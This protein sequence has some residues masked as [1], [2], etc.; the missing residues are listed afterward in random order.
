[1]DEKEFKKIKKDTMKTFIEH[2]SRLHKYIMILEA[3]WKK[4]KLQKTIPI[5]PEYYN[6]YT[7]SRFDHIKKEKERKTTIFS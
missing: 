2:I 1:M 4:V 5:Y 3:D 6:L 7:K